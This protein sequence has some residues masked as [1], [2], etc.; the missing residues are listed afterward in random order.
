MN[1][2]NEI[3]NRDNNITKS[4][5]KSIKIPNNI[6][7]EKTSPNKKSLNS[8]QK[9]NKSRNYSK[10]S[11]TP[12]C[13]LEPNIVRSILN[14]FDSVSS[15]LFQQSKLSLDVKIETSNNENFNPYNNIEENN[16][17]SKNSKE[18]YNN[19]KEIFNEIKENGEEGCKTK[20]TH[21]SSIKLK[22]LESYVQKFENK[23]KNN[24]KKSNN[25]SKFRLSNIINNS[26][27]NNIRIPLNFQK[28]AEIYNLLKT[29]NIVNNNVLDSKQITEMLN[30]DFYEQILPLKKLAELNVNLHK[31]TNFDPFSI[32]VSPLHNFNNNFINNNKLLINKKVR[33]IT[34]ND[35]NSFIKAFLFN[36]FENIILNAKNDNLIFIMYTISTKLALFNDENNNP[37]NLNIK[38]I[39][40]ILKIIFNHI[41][42]KDISEAYIVLINSFKV[43]S[44]FEKGLIYFVKY[45]LAQFIKDN[46]TFFSIS[47][48]KEIIPD[49]EKYFSDNS[50]FDYQLYIKENILPYC[51]EMQY[52]ILIYYILP[53]I[54]HINLI[55]YTNNYSN[56]LNKIIFKDKQNQNNTVINQDNNITLE[57]IV[58]FGNTSIL[59]NDEFYNKY[60]DLIKYKS[61]YKYPLDKIQQIPNSDL[62]LC[63]TCKIVSDKL[64]KVDSEIEPI[65]SNCLKNKI[66]EVISKKYLLLK[67]DGYFHEEY[68]CSKIKLTNSSNNN[69]YLSLNDIKILLPNHNNISEEIHNK[70]LSDTSCENCK[71]KFIN[72]KYCICPKP[73]GHLMCNDCFIFYIK[74]IKPNSNI[75]NKNEPNNDTLTFRCLYCNNQIQNLKNK[76]IYN[77]FEDINENTEK[78]HESLDIQKRNLCCKC[79]KRGVKY[80]FNILMKININNEKIYI[81][82]FLCVNCK[83]ILDRQ[84]RRDIKLSIPT[85]FYCVFCEDSHMYSLIKDNLKYLTAKDGKYEAC[86]FIY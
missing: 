60:K 31:E 43:N 57:L 8:I 32:S 21:L 37:L 12:N 44:E 13:A 80:S 7:K 50:T 78:A 14:P 20:I 1:I 55:I 67:E 75:L 29:S 38:E 63:D 23:N 6:I 42:N 70:I 35:G 47:Y 54:F 19:N 16:H 62:K 61:D 25:E 81:H 5:M 77:Y 15:N 10:N 66:L 52:N 68:Y 33:D 11:H 17:I 71:E 40:N 56:N 48:L 30:L 22:E 18:L 24:F 83:T 27:F 28:E 51:E 76:F 72:K 74:N 69:L 41:V 85:K 65:C 9:D 49:F 2:Q 3:K 73:C 34:S 45:S 58:Y 4:Q 26:P 46:Y 64:I 53:L 79:Q 39:L 82:H 59:Y 86:C 84:F 36:Y